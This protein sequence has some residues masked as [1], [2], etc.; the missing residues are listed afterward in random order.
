M[1]LKGAV[2]VNDGLRVLKERGRQMAFHG[3]KKEG[4][5]LLANAENRLK[6]WLV[7]MVPKRVETILR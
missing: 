4:A 1:V 7:P 2:F 5:W 6:N 3:D